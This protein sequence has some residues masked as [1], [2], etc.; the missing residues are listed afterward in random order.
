MTREWARSKPASRSAPKLAWR[1]MHWQRQ[2]RVDLLATSRHAKR[3]KLN[4]ENRSRSGI[5][6]SR[7][8]LPISSKHE[9]K[10]SL[11]HVVSL[12]QNKLVPS[13]TREWA[14]SKPASRDMHWQRRHRVDL[15]ATSRHA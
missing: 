1:D 3:H 14:R 7:I 11:G 15:L 4:D 6:S 2:H 8:A 9:R 13:M 12:V 10:H 5:K